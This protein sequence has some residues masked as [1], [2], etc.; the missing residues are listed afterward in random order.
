[1]PRY[2]IS[3]S[4]VLLCFL[5]LLLGGCGSSSNGN[6]DSGPE[7]KSDSD[8][9][10]PETC[11]PDGH[12]AYIDPDANRATGTFGLYMDSDRGAVL[13]NGKLDGK[14]FYMDIGGK[15]EFVSEQGIVKMEIYGLLTSNM[16]NAFIFQ[17][18]TDPPLNQEIRFGST[19]VAK[20]T[21]VLVEFDNDGNELGRDTIADVV[22][23]GITFS[24]F[25]LS[26]D[27]SVNGEL[28]IELESR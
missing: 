17:L 2:R 12:C 13:V 24:D 8:C 16:F 5:L 7:C 9:T 4:S 15:V 23:G 21:Y 22:A 11:Q 19:G 27:Q 28:D 18:P 3:I 20:G 26:A 25:S 1:M 6:P 10:P 14:G